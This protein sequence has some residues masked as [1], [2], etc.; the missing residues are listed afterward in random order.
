MHDSFEENNGDAVGH[1]T[2][3]ENLWGCGVSE[4]GFS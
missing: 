4:Y 2:S 3:Q 1:A